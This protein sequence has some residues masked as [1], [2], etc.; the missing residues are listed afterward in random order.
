MNEPVSEKN[1]S[2]VTLD[3]P[4]IRGN[5]TLAEITVRK[6]HSGALR[7]IRLQALI[8]MD[9]DSIMTVLP[10]VTTPALSKTELMLME[11][12]NLLQL[13]MALVTFLLPKSALSDSLPN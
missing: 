7:G 9:V 4:V 10:R 6:P 3:T 5:T 12:S 8:E 1:E 2:T 13:A 11:P